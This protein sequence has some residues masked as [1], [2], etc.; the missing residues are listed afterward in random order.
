MGMNA[1]LCT[2]S[3]KRLALIQ[4]EPEVFEELAASR[5]DSDIPGLLDLG[6]AW[7]A[8]DVLLSEGGRDALL[9]DAV[10]ARKGQK[11]DAEGEYGPPRV[12]APA[13]V[14]Q[15]SAALEELP[16]DFLR[17]RY[18]LLQ[19]R[20]VQGGYGQ[21]AAPAQQA[22]ELAELEGL[23]REVVALYAEAAEAGHSMMAAIV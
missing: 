11:L 15:I 13:R 7:E 9:G 12:L 4:E 16:A 2:L 19:G 20:T 1:L 6:K 10:L 18:P 8:L 22:R 17:T 5:H 23:L 14:R 3:A 21:K